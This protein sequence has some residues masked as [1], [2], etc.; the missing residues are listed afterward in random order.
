MWL[1]FEL[2]NLFIRNWH[3]VNLPAKPALRYFGYA[4]SFATIWPAIFEGAERSRCGA[5][6]PRRSRG[7]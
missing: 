7:P 1:V 4:W 5:G 2:Y 6:K 3:Y